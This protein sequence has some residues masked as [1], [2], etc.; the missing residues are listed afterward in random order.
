MRNTIQNQPEQIIQNKLSAIQRR[1]R[2]ER[3]FQN[4][5][6]FNLWGLLIVGLL[7]VANR[8]FPLPIPIGLAIALPIVVASAIA[9][10]LVLLGKVDPFEVARFV[11]QRLNLKERLGTALEA[12]RRRNAGDF[13]IL[14]VRD[15][16][17]A[18][19]GILPATVVSYTVP[20]TLKWLPIPMLLVGLSFF[21][22]RMYEIVP[23][24]N[25]SEQEAIHDAA[26]RLEG[27][28]SGLDETE[29]SK[30]VEETVKTLRNKRTG[31]QTAQ[32]KLSKLREE[33]QAQKNQLAENELDQAVETIS[34]LS[35]ISNLLGGANTAEIASELQELADQMAGLTEAQRTELDALLRQLAERLGGNPAAKNLVDQL[36]EIETEGVSPEMLAKIARSILEI[37]QQAKD[38]AQL[39]DI[40]EEIKTSRKNIGLAGIEMARKTGGVAGSDGG[41]G[42]E[43]ETGEARGTQIEAMYLETQPTEALQLRGATSDSEEFATASTQ[44]APG[45]EEEPTYMP[46]R[47]AYLNA[48]QAYAEAIE[49]DR[50]PVRYRQR[51]KD[52]LDAIAETSK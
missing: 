31:V 21:V 46:H 12:M 32:E 43:S 5:A 11:D 40:L 37:D 26:A 44:E 20:R 1:M 4:L 9:V 47:E 2:I 39:E 38:I 24:P 33:V 35:E 8:F 18:V 36:N 19:Q 13:A 23:P 42:E 14:Q 6:A 16:A 15:A 50:I 3:I 48:K 52:Y 27:A 22:P 30:Q 29:L 7:L 49:R 51:V 10:G 41:P 28:V 25:P 17:R 45:G 34:K